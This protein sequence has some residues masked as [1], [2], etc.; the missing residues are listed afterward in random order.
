MAREAILEVGCKENVEIVPSP[1][2]R[3]VSH[4]QSALTSRNPPMKYREEGHSRG[5][6]RVTARES[7]VVHIFAI[8]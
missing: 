1:T 7:V 2:I 3:A 5:E 8:F 4:N 6:Y